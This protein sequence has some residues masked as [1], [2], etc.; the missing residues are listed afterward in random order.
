MPNITSD[1]LTRI[2]NSNNSNTVEQDAYSSYLDM[3]R[4]TTGNEKRAMIRRTIT[5]KPQVCT[6]RPEFLAKVSEEKSAKPSSTSLYFLNAFKK[7]EEQQASEFRN[8]AKDER[9]TEELKALSPA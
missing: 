5:K 4:E 8:M 2:L 9:E 7:F 3:V 6:N 1:S